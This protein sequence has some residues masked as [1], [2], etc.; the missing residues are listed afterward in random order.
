MSTPFYCPPWRNDLLGKDDHKTA[1]LAVR[2]PHFPPRK[3]S[4][5][6]QNLFPRFCSNFADAIPVSVLSYDTGEVVSAIV[7]DLSGVVEHTRR[8]LPQAPTRRTAPFALWPDRTET[9]VRCLGGARRIDLPQEKGSGG[10]GS[11]SSWTR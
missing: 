2:K 3:G 5:N 6:R 8:D 4:S 1:S 11:S 9:P 10:E 7:L